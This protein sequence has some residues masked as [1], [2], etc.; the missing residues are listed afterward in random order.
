VS[1]AGSQM[2]E[3]IKTFVNKFFEECRMNDKGELIIPENFNNSNSILPYARMVVP[4]PDR[5][6][7]AF[8][9]PDEKKL[10]HSY[11][12]TYTNLGKYLEKIKYHDIMYGFDDFD[13]Y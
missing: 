3:E 9:E 7:I 4:S 1:V 2:M 12:G 13:T 6:I 11:T 10:Y 5:W 8:G